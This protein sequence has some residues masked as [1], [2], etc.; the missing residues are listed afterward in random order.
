MKFLEHLN[1]NESVFGK[2]RRPIVQF[3]IE[4]K[5][6][7]RMQRELFEKN[8]HKLSGTARGGS[9]LGRGAGR[10]G[11]APADTV[12]G[13]G[14]GRGKGDVCDFELCACSLQV[15]LSLSLSIRLSFLLRPV[16]SSLVPSSAVQSPTVSSR[17]LSDVVV[18][19]SFCFCLFVSVSVAL[20]PIQDKVQTFRELM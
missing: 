9:R 10:V 14:K 11:V 19:C 17:L 5:R 20:R 8:A 16:P 3:A 18:S 13:R 4:D 6:K 7:L 15:S 1:D 12:A 2:G